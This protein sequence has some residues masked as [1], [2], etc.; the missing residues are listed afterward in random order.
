MAEFKK[1]DVVVSLGEFDDHAFVSKAE[2]EYIVKELPK[3][4]ITEILRRNNKAS[5]RIFYVKVKEKQ[6]IQA[7]LFVE[8]MSVLRRATQQ[9]EFLYN[10]NFRQPFI[11]GKE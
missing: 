5:N 6:A 1:G 10:I 8:E 11:L 2:K 3:G 4:L 7:I 9:E